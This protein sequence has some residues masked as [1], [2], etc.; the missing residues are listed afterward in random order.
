M[1]FKVIDN[2]VIVDHSTNHYAITTPTKKKSP[3][4]YTKKNIDSL[5]LSIYSIFYRSVID[6]KLHKLGDNCPLLYALKGK[7]NLVVTKDS[8]KD[9]KVPF[10]QILEILKN[11]I[12]DKR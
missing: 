12:T 2:L 9:L 7:Q 5:N 11:E 3:C 8:M 4:I 6:R 10:Y 1:G